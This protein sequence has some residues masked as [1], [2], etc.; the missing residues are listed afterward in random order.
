[1]SERGGEIDER[2]ERNHRKLKLVEKIE[3]G[4]LVQT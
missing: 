3:K 2:K 1:M 4:K